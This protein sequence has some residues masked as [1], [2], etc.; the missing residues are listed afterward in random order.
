MVLDKFK[1]NSTLAQTPLFLQ[2]L[3]SWALAS[4]W[5]VAIT[6]IGMLANPENLKQISKMDP[7][8]RF[9]RT[10]AKQVKPE[11]ASLYAWFVVQNYLT[12]NSKIGKY[13]E[14][15]LETLLSYGAI[16]FMSMISYDIYKKIKQS[17]WPPKMPSRFW[18]NRV[19]FKGLH[20]VI[21][22]T[23]SHYIKEKLEE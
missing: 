20:G 4:L 19:F 21:F 16:G 14:K 6:P 18:M 8:Y 9:S 11:I 17:V 23:S 3:V 5:R 1:S 2:S 15:P 10:F 22:C 13:S 7:K 12:E